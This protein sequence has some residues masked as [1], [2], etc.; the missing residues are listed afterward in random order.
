MPLYEYRCADCRAKT[1]VLFRSIADGAAP[2]CSSCG[3]GNLVRLFSRFAAP[4]SEESRL[5]RMADP[6]NWGGVDENDPGSVSRFMKRMG[7]EMGDEFRDGMGGDFDESV[8]REMSGETGT[9]GGLAGPE[10]DA[11][12]G[13]AGGSDSGSGDV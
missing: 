6:S 8:D 3:S 10:P 1:T 11:D 7:R 9:G 5:E 2:A 13:P 12:P 4:R